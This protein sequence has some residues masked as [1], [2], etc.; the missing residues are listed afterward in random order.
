MAS[1]TSATPR[2]PDNE[3]LTLRSDR[4]AGSRL[5]HPG[6]DREVEPTSYHPDMTGGQSRW[7]RLAL[8]RDSLLGL[9]AL[10]AVVC[11]SC[12]AGLVRAASA[13]TAWGIHADLTDGNGFNGVLW[14]AFFAALGG[15]LASLV[16]LVAVI[17][18]CLNSI[19]RPP[20]PADAAAA[21]GPAE[22]PTE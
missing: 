18:V 20:A 15:V 16:G 7:R 10:L 4:N 11:A 3:D 12:I 5:G 9:I 22:Y 19:R 13:Q 17:V 2:R 8:R 14:L 1:R 6:S 21:F